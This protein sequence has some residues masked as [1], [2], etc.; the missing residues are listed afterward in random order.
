VA[1]DIL[2]THNFVGGAKI[3]GLPQGGASGEPVTYEQ[4]LAAGEGL[5]WKDDVD[6][7]S[8]ANINLLSPGATIDGVTMSNG[9]RFLAKDQSTG[10]E[11]GIYIWNGASTPATRALDMNS[12]LEFNSAI[13]PVREGGTANENTTWRVTIANP[14]V[15]TDPITIA[16]FATGVAAASETAAGILELATQ[17]ETNTGTDDTRAVTPLK[18]ASWTGAAKRYSTT[19]GD[20]SST[21][22]TVTHNLGTR[23]CVPVVYKASGNYDNVDCDIRRPSTNALDLLFAAAPSS[24]SLRCTVLA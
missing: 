21:S 22:I 20:G 6:A 12:S 7:A 4:F 3:T 24:N 18:L 17:A 15:G 11:N 2:T 1:K 5:A 14:V 8:V 9:M 23:D 10:A 19:V 16:A 13:I